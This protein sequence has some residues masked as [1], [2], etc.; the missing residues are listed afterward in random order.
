MGQVLIIKNLYHINSF[1]TSQI[2]LKLLFEQGILKENPYV[3][4]FIWLFK[5]R[6][7][8]FYLPD[9]REFQGQDTFFNKAM[10]CISQIRLVINSNTDVIKAFVK[11]G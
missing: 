11:Q 10:N 3:S 9:I 1:L 2:F 4:D 5:E 6:K 8:P 7:V